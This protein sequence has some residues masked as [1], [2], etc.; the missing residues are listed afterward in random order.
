MY[1]RLGFVKED[2]MV[3]YYLN[4]GDAYRLKLWVDR[5]SVLSRWAPF[6]LEEA[7]ALAAAAEQQQQQL[8]QQVV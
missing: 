1:T 4:G 6:L 8:Q 3:K 5:T 7:A 2:K